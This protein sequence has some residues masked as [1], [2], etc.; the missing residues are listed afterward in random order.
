MQQPQQ[1]PNTP[2][3]LFANS[4]EEERNSPILLT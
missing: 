1:I 2:E 3:T 4:K